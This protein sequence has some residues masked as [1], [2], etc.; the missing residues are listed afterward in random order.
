MCEGVGGAVVAPFGVGGAAAALA[1]APRP[2]MPGDARELRRSA[3]TISVKEGS[4]APTAPQR[5]PRHG[6]QPQAE[7]GEPGP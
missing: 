4:F 3:P 5:A 1:A 6:R 7:R 2:D